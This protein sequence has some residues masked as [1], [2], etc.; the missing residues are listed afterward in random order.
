[1]QNRSNEVK[2]FIELETPFEFF[3]YFFDKD[4]SQKI[5]EQSNFYMIQKD[6]N[7]AATVTVKDLQICLDIC[8]SFICQTVNLFETIN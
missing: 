1:M 3:N 2:N 5:V 7:Q 4:L 6:R 8:P